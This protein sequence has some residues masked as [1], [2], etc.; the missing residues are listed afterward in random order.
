[1]DIHL[2]FRDFE[3]SD[4][5]RF[6]VEKRAARALAPYD[7]VVATRVIL[8]RPHHQRGSAFRVTIDVVLPRDEVVVSQRDA[9]TGHTDLHAAIDDAFDD[10]E[11]QLREHAG[12][13]ARS[14]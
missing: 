6:H 11:R 1:M 12:K 3:P 10:L 8:A 13:R 2:T 9:A 4:A 14:A 5:V 7:R